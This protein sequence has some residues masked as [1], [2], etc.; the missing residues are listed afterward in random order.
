MA[1]VKKLTI[2][3]IDGNRTTYDIKDNISGY[4]ATSNKINNIYSSST[5][6]EYPSAKAVYDFSN[7]YASI[8][9]L[10]SDWSQTTVEGENCYYCTKSLPGGAIG[11]HPTVACLH[12]R[13]SNLEVENDAFAF[14]FKVVEGN[15][16][17]TFYASEI[18]AINFTVQVVDY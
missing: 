5:T 3:N 9:L 18:P 8:P 11:V 10:T 15:D 1:N 2:Y 16:S 14:V 4:E 6:G 13:P 7:K 12:V 17:I